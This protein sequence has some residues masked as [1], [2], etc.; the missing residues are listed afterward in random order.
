MNFFPMK[1]INTGLEISSDKIRSALVIRQRNNSFIKKL[2]DVTLSEN[3][4]KPSFKKENIVDVKAFQDALKIINKEINLKKIG[5]ALPDSS[6]KVLIRTFKEL[7]KKA[8]EIDEMVLWNISSSID[9]PAKDIRG[10]WKNNGKNADNN[11]VFLIVFGLEKIIS[12]YEDV[13]KEVGISPLMIGPSGLSQFNFYSPVVPDKGNVAYLGLF[14]DL[15][16]IFVF[17]EGIPVFYKIIKKG[18]LGNQ[19]VSTINDVDLLMQ[20][21]KS[22]N[23]DIEIKQFFIAS[24]IKSRLRMTQ[25]LQEAGQYNFTIIDERQLIGFDIRFKIRPENNPLPF[26]SNVLGAAQSL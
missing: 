7:P 24:H 10:S 13:L 5:V 17:S 23:P 21:Y 2:F 1:K 9:L 20:Y 11:Y 8:Q 3:I 4:I 19:N 15:L 26:Y 25:V 22:E 6:V 16:N 18:I 12:Q 14:D